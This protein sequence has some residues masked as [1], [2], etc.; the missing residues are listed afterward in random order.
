MVIKDSQTDK[1]IRS[2]INH[3]SKE[4]QDLFMSFI[5]DDSDLLESIKKTS[6]EKEVELLFDEVIKKE[7]DKL[8]NIFK[9]YK[10]DLNALKDKQDSTLL[11]EIIAK[12]I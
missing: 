12:Q 5:R 4:K 1:L 3:L 2:K 8:N 6:S 11:E 7:K 10:K 9:N